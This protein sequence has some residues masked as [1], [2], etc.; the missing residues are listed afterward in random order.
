MTASDVSLVARV[1]ASD[2]RAAF[3]LLIR[4]HQSGLRNFLNRLTQNDTNR[5]DDLAQDAFINAYRAIHTFKGNAKFSSWLYRIGYNLFLNDQRSRYPELEFDEEQHTRPVDDAST[6]SNSLDV[7]RALQQL[8]IRQQAVFDLH[9]QKGMTHQEIE[10]ALELPL[11]TI[12]SDL[13]RGREILKSILKESN[14]S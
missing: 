6:L 7:H 13:V 2:D 14:E 12:K 10:V 1:V 4:R 8:S 9:Y 3:E 5:A 11:G